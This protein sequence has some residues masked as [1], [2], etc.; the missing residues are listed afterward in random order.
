MNADNIDV[1]SAEVDLLTSLQQGDQ[2]AFEL[3]YSRY[4]SAIYRNI[5]RMVKSVE[6]AED[7]LQVVFLKV[8]DK[9]AVLDTEKSFKS[10]LYRVAENIVYDY[11]RKAARDR[12]MLS[13]MMLHGENSYQHIEKWVDE[14]ENKAILEKAIA[15]L[16]PK[17]QQIYQLC[18]LEGYSYDQISKMLGISP[19]TVNDHIVK[20]SK[21]VKEYLLNTRYYIPLLI[22]LSM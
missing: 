12:N 8:W 7:L 17:R 21:V 5:L 11:F 22:L 14:K 16:S 18:K 2:H 3:L 15:Q 4:S 20:A 1:D 19:A 13:K 6:T 9:R 10:F